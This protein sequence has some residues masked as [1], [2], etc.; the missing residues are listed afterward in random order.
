M[1]ER[2][3][4][5]TNPVNF[6]YN[7]KTIKFPYLTV[8]YKC[9]AYAETIPLLKALGGS[10]EYDKKTGT[11]TCRYDGD[12]LVFKDFS[13]SYTINGKKK[14][15]KYEMRRMQYD[16]AYVPVKDICDVLGLEYNV[17]STRSL[18]VIEEQFE[19]APKLVEIRKPQKEL[20]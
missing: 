8:Y 6:K 16:L 18:Y 7:G 11:L 2:Y 14:K 17:I 13:K 5:Y 1:I 10:A 19:D 3:D 9:Q 15:L 4:Y 12:I 20:G